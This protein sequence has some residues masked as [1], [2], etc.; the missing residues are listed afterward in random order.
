MKHN[1]I[2]NTEELEKYYF[3]NIFNITRKLK[4]TPIVWQELFDINTQLDPNVVVHVWKGGFNATVQKVNY[5][6]YTMY[7]SMCC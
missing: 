1:E 2:N 5:Q 4:T 7:Y 3:K 6:L